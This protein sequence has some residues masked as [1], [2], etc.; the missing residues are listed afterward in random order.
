MNKENFRKQISSG[1]F[2]ANKLFYFLSA[3]EKR[4]G[5][6]PAAK[7]ECEKHPLSQLR[8]STMTSETVSE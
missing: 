7:L 2:E 3:W 8:T 6:P 5:N 4:V 1:V